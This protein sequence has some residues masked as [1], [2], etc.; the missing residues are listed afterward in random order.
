MLCD[1]KKWPV[2]VSCVLLLGIAGC[3]AN[4]HIQPQSPAQRFSNYSFDQTSSLDSRI[5][6]PPAFVLE[7]LNNYDKVVYRAYPPTSEE[8]SHAREYLSL[9]PKGYQSILGSHL[10][11][12]YF[13]E[14]LKGS[15]L[16]EFVYDEAKNLYAFIA[17]NSATLSV[18]MSDWLTLRDNSCFKPDGS[19][20]RLFSSCSGSYTG[21][22][23]AILHESS[24]VVD[25][26]LHHHPNQAP[27]DE[28]A[29]PFVASFWKGFTQPVPKFDFPQRKNL[30]FYGLG[31]GPKLSIKDALPTY[32]ALAQSPFASLYGSQT[33]LED[34][35]E[36][37]TWSYYSKVLH[38]E[39]STTVTQDGQTSFVYSPMDN[40]LVSQRA[41]A[42]VDLF[43]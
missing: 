38:Q 27:K 36:L 29:F 13:I 11:G 43:N 15:A 40:P 28:R 42:L 35:A 16:T 7:Y 21:F 3:A 6:T 34:F 26:V 17:F 4:S 41:L 23:Y 32:R 18:P 10:L 1:V 39:Y 14:D 22:L 30:A 25:A 5:T 2:L 37:F 24:H 19:N 33:I 12:I 20:A 9:L 8:L 31:G